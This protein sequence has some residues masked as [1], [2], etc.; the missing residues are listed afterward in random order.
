MN[1]AMSHKMAAK[2]YIVDKKGNPTA[3]IIPVEDFLSMLEEIE[4]YRVIRQLSQSAEFARLIR[5]GLEDVRKNRVR[6]WKDA[7]D[8]L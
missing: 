1:M 7:W 2:Q 4:D 6:H 8:E 5:K 3:V